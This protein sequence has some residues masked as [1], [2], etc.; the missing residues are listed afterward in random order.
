MRSSRAYFS[1]LLQHTYR[2]QKQLKIA[3]D[4]QADTDAGGSPF[5]PRPSSSRAHSAAT[6]TLEKAMLELDDEQYMPEGLETSVWQRFVETRRQK[7]E[8]EQQVSFAISRHKTSRE[9]GTN[10]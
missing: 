6:R 9:L 2:G 8:S 7:V 5:S 10:N 3:A 4:T 1:L